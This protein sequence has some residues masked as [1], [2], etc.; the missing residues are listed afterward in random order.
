LLA[1]ST[2]KPVAERTAKWAE[3]FSA[4]LTASALLVAG[5][6][7]RDQVVATRAQVKATND[8]VELNRDQLQLNREERERDRRRF[9]ARVAIFSPLSVGYERGPFSRDQVI[10]TM[11]N[12]GPAN[13][14]GMIVIFEVRGPDVKKNG[15]ATPAP[16]EYNAASIP[17]LP[18]CMEVEFPFGDFGFNEADVSQMGIAYASFVDSNGVK[19]EATPTYFAQELGKLPIGK[20]IRD[21]AASQDQLL[22]VTDSKPK[23]L[24]DCDEGA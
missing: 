6:A 18:P 22:S 12:R 3:V 8:Q 24:E 11:Q 5:L 13:I 21:Q 2:A 15:V 9:A 14:T 10:G 17:L 23:P 20:E 1:D 7:F 16:A 19:W 4:L